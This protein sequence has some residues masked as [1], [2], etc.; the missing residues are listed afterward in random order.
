MIVSINTKKVSKFIIRHKG[1]LITA[2]ISYLL[3][4][5]QIRTNKSLMD[6]ITYKGLD[7]EYFQYH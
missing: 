5:E 7:N 3:M 2:G 6:F 1:V 4:K